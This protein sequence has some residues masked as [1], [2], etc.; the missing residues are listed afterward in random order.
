[1]RIV[2][3]PVL[4]TLCLLPF[5]SNAQVQDDQIPL[6]Q[7]MRYLS[8]EE[9]YLPVRTNVDFIETPPPIGVPRMVA[10]YEPMQAVLIRYPFGIPYSLIREMANDIQVVTIVSSE[11]QANTVLG[12]YQGNNVNTA[13]C[14]FLVAPSDSYWTR[15]Y[16]PWF[17]FDGN[18]QPGIVD[19]PYNRPRPNDN[20]IPA[21]VAT[22]LGIN[23]FGMNVSHTGGNMM[24]DGYTIGASTDLV[25]EENQSQSPAQIALKFQNYL[26]IN[27]YDVLPDPLG[28]YIKHIDCWGKY[29]A[30]DKVLIGRVLPSDP[31]YNDF[32]AAANFFATTPSAYG[33][34]YKVYRVFT[35]GGNPATPYTNSLILN[36]KVFVPTTGSQHDNAALAV[37]QQAMPGYEII[38]ILHSSGSTRWQNTDALHCRTHE[39]ADIGKLFVD[40]MP[41]YNIQLWSDSITIDANIIAYSGQQLTADSLRVFY[42]INNQ[43]FNAVPMMHVTGDQYRAYISNYTSFDTIRYFITAADA[44]GR[45]LKHPIMGKLDPH[46]FFMGEQVFNQLSFSPDSLVFDAEL[47]GQFVIRNQTQASVTIQQ[48]EK[49]PEDWFIML[50]NLPQ[51]PVTLN[52]NDSLSVDVWVILP[53]NRPYTPMA[54]DTAVI[55]IQSGIGNYEFKVYVNKELL[56]GTTAETQLPVISASPNP[57]GQHV[58]FAVSNL[59]N[60]AVLQVFDVTGKVVYSRKVDAG[61]TQQLSWDGRNGQGNFVKSGVYLYQLRSSGHVVHG[62]L[63]KM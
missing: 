7:K 3:Y 50:P 41:K 53:V 1:M 39:I 9:M 24:A 63:V 45:R 14:S 49:K 5:I 58:S 13:N 23:L 12:L 10:E 55:E 56:I 54:Y 35:P 8:E 31:R 60:D 36:N 47:E 17:I 38:P 42:S 11:S 40:H 44:S 18:K 59:R 19:F 15:D 33:Y 20:N 26:G 46:R 34:P 22:M 52:P 29:L 32:E 30:P 2:L 25:Y 61:A 37:Y 48:I 51:F 6:W 43:E 27:R 57:F 28:D 21:R 62:K 4:F 16:G